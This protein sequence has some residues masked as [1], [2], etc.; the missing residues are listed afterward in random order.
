MS[1]LSHECRRAS[2]S[3]AMRSKT[4]DIYR[5]PPAEADCRHGHHGNAPYKENS[6]VDP[7]KQD[8]SVPTT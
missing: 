3:W 7:G 4:G 2:S 5:K 8:H 1:R 6:F